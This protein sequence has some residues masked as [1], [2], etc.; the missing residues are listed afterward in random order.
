MVTMHGMNNIKNAH[1]ILGTTLLKR[2]RRSWD[3]KLY[4]TKIGC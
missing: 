2:K 3:I 1:R 4:L